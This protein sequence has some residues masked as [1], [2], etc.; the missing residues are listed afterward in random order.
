MAYVGRTMKY[1]TRNGMDQTEISAD[2]V[3]IQLDD[4]TVLEL[5][6]DTA[7]HICLRSAGYKTLLIAP[8]CGN[9]VEIVR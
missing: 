4:G 8:V 9:M 7:G 6:F 2:L 3:G 5:S 1:I